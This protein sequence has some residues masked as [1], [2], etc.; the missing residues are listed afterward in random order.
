MRT[1]YI[2]GYDGVTGPL[3]LGACLDAGASTQA[4][5]AGWQQL[6]LPEVALTSQRL[7]Y[8]AGLATC[9]VCEEI[10]EPMAILQLYGTLVNTLEQSAAPNRVQQRLRRILERFTQAVGRVQ[11]TDAPGADAFGA[12]FL[13]DVLYFG[14]AVVWALEEL[15]IEHIIAAPIPLSTGFLTLAQERVP[16]PH[17]LTAALSRGVPVYGEGVTSAGERTSVSGAAILTAC[18]DGFG[19]LPDMTIATTGYGMVPAVPEGPT[20][21]LQM[22]VG[23][24]TGPAAAER[25]AVI[26][27]NIDD[28]NPE[29][30][31]CVA[32]RLFAHGALDV[33]LTP[34]FMK[35]NRPAN[36][37]TVL[38][39][40]Q[41]V[42]TLATVMLQETSTFGVRVHEVWRHKLDRF[43]RQVETRYGL[44]PV[45]CGVLHGRI[46]Q[47]AP[48]YEACKRVA[49]ERGLPVRLV[50]AEA[51]SCAAPWL[52]SVLPTSGPGQ[53]G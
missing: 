43:H 21:S 29:F 40:V 31:E 12:P 26:E 25:I 49:L 35:K 33:T 32:E 4:I 17:P 38:A 22:F 28:M 52:H 13:P 39:P 14:S 19:A 10:P 41:A 8:A 44:I 11:G 51:A 47:A 5:Q 1:A 7:P 23:D 36:T 34:L 24:L 18:A 46:V 37:L 20:R 9:A 42:T 48:E 53:P 30:Y 3:L 45:K 27:A 6:G 2:H 50:Y 15:T 16:Q